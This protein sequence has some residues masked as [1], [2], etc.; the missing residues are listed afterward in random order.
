MS[1]A[2][3][4]DSMTFFSI[5]AS[6]FAAMS[7]PRMYCNIWPTESKLSGTGILTQTDHHTILAKVQVPKRWSAV[8]I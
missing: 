3:F 4:K 2:I 5:L 8:S 7:L 6:F 1:Q